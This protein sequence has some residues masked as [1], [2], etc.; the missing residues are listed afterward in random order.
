[1]ALL[2]VALDGFGHAA[3]MGDTVQLPT[4]IQERWLWPKS[5]DTGTP[6]AFPMRSYMAMPRPIEVSSATIEG[7]GAHVP[8]Y[9]LLRIAS[10][11]LPETEAS[12]VGVHDVNGSARG[13]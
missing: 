11:G 12:V 5:L 10:H 3:G 13:P 1:M 2:G 7:I 6:A 8:V 9:P 4:A